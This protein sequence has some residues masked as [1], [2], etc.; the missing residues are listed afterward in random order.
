LISAIPVV[1]IVTLLSFLIMQ[2]I[3][4]DPAAAIAGLQATPVEI[5]LIREKLGLNRPL[6]EQLISWYGRLLQGD[7]GD[8]LL[9]GR[10]VTVA[11][12]ERIPVTLSLTVYAFV[13]ILAIAVGSGIVAALKHN[14]LIDQLMMTLALLGLSLPNFWLGLMLIVL[15]AVHLGWFPTA[16]YV[17]IMEDFRGWL[18][19]ATLPAISLSLL[20]IG[21]LARITRSTMLEVLN[22]DYIRTARAKGMPGWKIVLKHALRNVMIPITTVS[23]IVLSLLIGGSIVIETVYSIPGLGRLI[24]SAVLRRDYPVI[25]GTMLFI[26][27]CFILINLIVDLLY[28][29][30]DPRVRLERPHD[31]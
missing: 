8:S 5:E 31:Q 14:T 10:S 25:Q 16:G 24:G 11:I 13:F 22:Q 26:A 12:L 27:C 1:F 3:P 20:Q 29:A 7:L 23:G 18:R 30:I 15:F 9:L 21:L 6:W 19:G 2:L 4:G 17:P 28:A